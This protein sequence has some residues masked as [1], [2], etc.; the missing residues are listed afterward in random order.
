M[1]ENYD[2]KLLETFVMKHMLNMSQESLSPEYFECFITIY[3][4]L[5]TTRKLQILQILD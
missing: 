3:N 1:E 2:K 5:I 4:Q